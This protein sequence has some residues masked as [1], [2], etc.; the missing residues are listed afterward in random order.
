M[1]FLTS[2]RTWFPEG[3]GDGVLDVAASL[4]FDLADGVLDAELSPI[5]QRD[6]VTGAVLGMLDGSFRATRCPSPL[7]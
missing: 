5:L 4:T 2:A 3:A 6:D 7:Y 1:P